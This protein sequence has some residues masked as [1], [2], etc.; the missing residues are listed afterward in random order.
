MHFLTKCT[1]PRGNHTPHTPTPGGSSPAR[2]FSGRENVDA[3]Q[4]VSIPD[5][6]S[7]E[8]PSSE[9]SIKK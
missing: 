4:K 8:P 5:S 9:P 7:K 6:P 2:E 1:H 3:L